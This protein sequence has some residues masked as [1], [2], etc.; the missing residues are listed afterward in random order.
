MTLKEFRALD[1]NEQA[2]IVWA[3][4]FLDCL[5]KANFYVHLYEVQGFYAKVY[6]TYEANEI[7]RIRAFK[8]TSL[9]HPFL[10]SISIDQ[11]QL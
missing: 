8:N 5:A 11:L 10:K 9:L 3:G 6:Y 7:I 2:N 4:T 1:I